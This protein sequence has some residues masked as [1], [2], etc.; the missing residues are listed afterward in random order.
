[1]KVRFLDCRQIV[2]R[3][4]EWATAGW[5][6]KVERVDHVNIADEIFG[7]RAIRD[8]PDSL[9]YPQRSSHMAHPW[10][11]R[12]GRTPHGE[13]CDLDPGRLESLPEAVGVPG[14]SC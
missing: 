14:D 8:R 4:H 12:T 2:D 5:W 1:M 6:V 13:R 3:R 9:D 11:C 10:G 7:R